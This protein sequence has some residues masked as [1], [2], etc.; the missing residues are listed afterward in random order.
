LT[1]VEFK[2]RYSADD[3]KYKDWRSVF[4]KAVRGNWFKL[5]W[6]DA[7]GY[8]LTALGQQNM[9]A[10]INRDKREEQ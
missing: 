6:H 4:V 2:A 9:T 10:M 7:N 1:W 8:Q 3:K 5:W